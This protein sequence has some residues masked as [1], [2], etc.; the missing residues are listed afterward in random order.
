MTSIVI[1]NNEHFFKLTHSFDAQN[2]TRTYTADLTL[3]EIWDM[4][5]S[6][7]PMDNKWHA[8]TIEEYIHKVIQQKVYQIFYQNN[9][10]QISLD[11]DR[12]TEGNVAKLNTAYMIKK[13]I[14]SGGGITDP[15]SVSKFPNNTNPVHPGGSRLLLTKCYN[16]KIPVI[17]TDYRND[18]IDYTWAKTI[19]KLSYDF[20]N[21]YN[22]F[23]YEN[24]K[25][26]NGAS[27]SQAGA[28]L[29]IMFKQVQSHSEKAAV[30]MHPQRA[31]IERT[32]FLKDDKK[33]YV[34]NLLLAEKQDGMW[35]VNMKEEYK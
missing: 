28:G 33:I 3:R 14:L 6:Q 27:Y 15:V 16:G 26:T 35:A 5:Y 10:N 8:K 23:M 9:V 31:N 29:D 19:D 18:N 22:I 1:Q 17:I 20:T 30:F 34:N 32:F 24:T 21:K 2:N 12:I 13:E 11:D 25:H 7:N 4:Y